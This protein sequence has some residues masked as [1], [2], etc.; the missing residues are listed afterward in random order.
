M[1][2]ST[3]SN[4]MKKKYTFQKYCDYLAYTRRD[5][6]CKHPRIELIECEN[7]LYYRALNWLYSRNETINRRDWNFMCRR[8]NIEPNV[9]I[10]HKL[11][12]KNGEVLN[13]CGEFPRNI[14]INDVKSAGIILI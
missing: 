3:I 4:I 11:I 12:L 13:I 9:I 5:R 8:L 6:K 14:L 10:P 2:W 1:A 7:I